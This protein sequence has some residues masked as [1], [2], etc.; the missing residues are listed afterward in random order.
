MKGSKMA[1]PKNY[2][3]DT[4]SVAC[5]KCGESWLTSQATFDACGY[6]LGVACPPCELA[7]YRE[8]GLNF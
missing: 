3:E 8:R 6:R 2:Y 7:W 1:K 5:S 4:I